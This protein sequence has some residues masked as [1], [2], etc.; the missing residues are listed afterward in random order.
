MNKKTLIELLVV[1][2]ALSITGWV[3]YSSFFAGNSTSSA[4]QAVPT[5]IGRPDISSTLLSNGDKLDFSVLDRQNLKYGQITYPSVS[6][7]ELNSA[8]S[9]DDLIKQAGQ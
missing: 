7:T 2:I 6:P 8:R 9:L 4:T 5:A 3:L 1:V